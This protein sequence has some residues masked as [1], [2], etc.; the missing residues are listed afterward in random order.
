MKKLLS[1]LLGL[2]LL[3]ALALPTNAVVSSTRVGDAAYTIL[4]TDTNI[5]TTTA[6]TT[7]R[8]WTL[9]APSTTCI[10]QTCQPPTNQLVI[11]DIAGAFSTASPLT[12]GRPTGVTINGNA[13]DLIVSGA[14]AR[15]VLVPTSSTNWKVTVTGDYRVATVAV[16]NVV[17]LTTATAANI[18]S[19]SLSQGLWS[20]S[21]VVHRNL[22]ATTSVTQLKTSISATTATSGT[23]DAS[24]MNQWST[25]ANVMAANTSHTIGPIV[26]ALTATATRYL[27]A[28]DT[29]T[30]D[31][32]GGYGQLT[33]VRLS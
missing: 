30:V 21:G 27:V 22:A 16:A 19:L 12:F 5:V 28:Q 29:F 9:P 23:L 32:N 6:F 10:G 4:P 8:T 17:A 18:T 20:C 11:L 31:T 13:A 14:G 15:I 1:G 33:C 2:G 26:F 24:T 25:A 7:G 3:L